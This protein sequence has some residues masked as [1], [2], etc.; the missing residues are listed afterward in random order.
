[1]R[2]LVRASNVSGVSENN[3]RPRRA[4]SVDVW[5]WTPTEP[6]LLLTGTTVEL[7][8]EDAVLS[9][10]K[11][12]EAA[13]DLKLRIAIPGRP[14]L[15]EATVVRRVPPDLVTVAFDSIDAYEQG[16]IRAFIDA[17]E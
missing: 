17:S 3:Y 4:R 11:L 6:N 7:G 13:V 9:L 14:T 1:M 16:R 5:A 15:M 10:P 8:T 12:P 2:P